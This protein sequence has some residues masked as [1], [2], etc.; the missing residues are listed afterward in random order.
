VVYL[1]KSKPGLEVA[2][3]AKE[4]IKQIGSGVS[5]WRTMTVKAAKALLA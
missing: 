3:K 1:V 4:L 5:A 2:L